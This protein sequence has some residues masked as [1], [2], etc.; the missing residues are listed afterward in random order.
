MGVSPQ[1][2][3]VQVLNSY[4]DVPQLFTFDKWHYVEVCFRQSQVTGET[5][6]LLWVDDQPLKLLEVQDRYVENVNYE[7]IVGRDFPGILRTL[8]L[9]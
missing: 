7:V 1:S 6:V 3:R 8:T 9:S 5:N 2:V 4:H